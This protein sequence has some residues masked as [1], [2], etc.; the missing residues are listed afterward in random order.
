MW[1]RDQ[2]W[3]STIIWKPENV[4]TDH[5]SRKQTHGSREIFWLRRA[6]RKT[7]W[8][9]LRL[10]EAHASLA[11]QSERG[12]AVN[13][14]VLRLR[15]ASL[16][17]HA[18][19]GRGARAAR[20]IDS[21]V[22]TGEIGPVAERPLLGRPDRSLRGTCSLNGRAWMAGAAIGTVWR[23]VAAQPPCLSGSG[24]RTSGAC[25]MW[26]RGIPACISGGGVRWGGCPQWSAGHVI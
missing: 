8:I 18:Q 7:L 6:Q 16:G 10:R 19:G 21:A 20:D 9:F 26:W 5:F 13:P 2:P 4:D 24:A 1:A 12:G 25:G 15:G 3:F 23:G 22:W 17:A 14:G 11:E